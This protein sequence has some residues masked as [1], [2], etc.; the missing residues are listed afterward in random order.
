MAGLTLEKLRKYTNND[1]GTFVYYEKFKK[2][3][4]DKNSK[5]KTIN[6][7]SVNIVKIND[8]NGKEIGINGLNEYF[9][10]NSTLANEKYSKNIV[11]IDSKNN[12]WKLNEFLT[13]NVTTID[14]TLNNKD[15]TPQQLGL[16]YSSYKSITKFDSDVH[17]ALSI[18]K[19]PIEA[20]TFCKNL[21]N[22]VAT[23]RNTNKTT[24]TRYMKFKI[25]KVEL[26]IPYSKQ[27]TELKNSLYQKDINIIGKNFGEVLAMRWCLSRKKYYNYIGFNFP[28]VANEPLVDAY[29]FTKN[30]N[31]STVKNKLSVKFKT[32][33]A[34]SIASISSSIDENDFNKYPNLKTKAAI[35]K[36]FDSDKYK[37]KESGTSSDKFLKT[38]YLLNS[39]NKIIDNKKFNSTKELN[40]FIENL[41]KTEKTDKDKIDKFNKTFNNFFKF[42]GRFPSDNSIKSILLR[43]HNSSQYFNLI[44]G[45]LAYYLVD[46]LNDDDDD[47]KYI[48]NFYGKKNQID[49]IY[50]DFGSNSISFKSKEFADNKFKFS[51][52]GSAL[53]ANRSNI[54]FE[55]V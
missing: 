44:C 17:H 39:K 55:M 5:I 26:T 11:F 27:I 23:T 21:Y 12:E 30:T 22:L 45:P 16:T 53:S 29:I 46:I 51:Y 35:L 15:F 52:N 36:N 19:R 1:D 2:L 18:S 4:L 43:Q 42:I 50:V 32:G 28:V 8:K 38:Y 7:Q 10:K 3:L 54:K 25:D 6:G 31:E 48:L 37:S 24:K 34:A 49:Q 20:V 47:F 40:E 33:A 9:V 41:L 13:T 14:R